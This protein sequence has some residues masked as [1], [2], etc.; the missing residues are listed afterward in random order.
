MDRILCG[1]PHVGCYIDDVIIGGSTLLDCKEWLEQVLQRLQAHNVTLQEENCKFF[2]SE[3]RYLGHRISAAEIHPLGSKI[4]EITAAPE[5]T[6]ATDRKSFLGIVSFYSQVSGELGNRGS[7]AL[8]TF[9]EK[10]AAALARR[11]R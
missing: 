8:R 3:V 7:T 4:R 2:Q 11:M 10:F 6:N 1:I 9:K 5:A